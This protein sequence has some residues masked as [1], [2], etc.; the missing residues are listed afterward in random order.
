MRARSLLMDFPAKVTTMICS[1]DRSLPVLEG[2]DVVAYFSLEP[3]SR[4]VKGSAQH[5]SEYLGY[6]FYFS[7]KENKLVFEVGV[8]ELRCFER[9]IR[10]FPLVGRDAS[11]SEAPRYERY[12]ALR[13]LVVR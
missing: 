9:C 13:L 8:V 12:V 5:I 7:S 11:S 3:G 1:G 4:A 10:R 2:T 6:L